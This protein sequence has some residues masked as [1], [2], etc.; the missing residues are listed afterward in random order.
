MTET[1]IPAIDETKAEIERLDLRTQLFIDGEFRDAPAAGGSSPRTR[2]PAGR[3]PR[4]PR[5]ARPTSTSPSRRRAGPP[6]TGAGRAS[7]PATASGSSS[8]GRT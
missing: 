8:A 5:A 4:S 1:L 2:R 6:T 7:A 3:S